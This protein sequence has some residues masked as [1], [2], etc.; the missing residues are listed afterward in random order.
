[1]RMGLRVEARGTRGLAAALPVRETD[2]GVVLPVRKAVLAERVAVAARW[3]AC[4]GIGV[5]RRTQGR[6]IR[7]RVGVPGAVYITNK[8]PD[9]LPLL[10]VRNPLVRRHVDVS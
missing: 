10:R 6:C 5:P 3:L 9:V 2:A 7:P 4:R 8:T 1:M